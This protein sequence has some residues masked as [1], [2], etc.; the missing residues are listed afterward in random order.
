MRLPKYSSGSL[1]SAAA[2]AVEVIA[3]CSIV[4]EGSPSKVV[5][6]LPSSSISRLK[7]LMICSGL[8]SINWLKFLAVSFGVALNLSEFLPE[9][10]D[11][12][13][14]FNSGDGMAFKIL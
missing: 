10:W 3:S 4:S 12:I 9:I 13:A 14:A 1:F 2:E 8:Y 11:C 5:I 6:F 7:A